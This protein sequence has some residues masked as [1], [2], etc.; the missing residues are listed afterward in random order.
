MAEA[1]GIEQRGADF[2]EFWD[3]LLAFIEDRRVIPVVGAELHTVMI[4]GQE[5]S[6]FRTL[7]MKLLEKY[8]IMPTEEGTQGPIGNKSVVLRPNL[9]LNDSV[10]AIFN[11]IE[12]RAAN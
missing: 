12:R 1:E 4:H 5:V 10:C 7:A 8:D 11:T 6:L 2:E 9:E 3:D